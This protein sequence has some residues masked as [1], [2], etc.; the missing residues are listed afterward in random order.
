[1]YRL[2]HAYSN[3]AVQAGGTRPA[4]TA[5]AFDPVIYQ[6]APQPQLH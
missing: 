1:M 3:L 6:G 4:L 2:G 5:N